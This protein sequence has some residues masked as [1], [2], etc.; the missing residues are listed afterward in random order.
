MKPRL[1]FTIFGVFIQSWLAQ[2]LARR[3]N[4]RHGASEAPPEPDSDAATVGP[5][6]SGARF[7]QPRLDL[8][9]R[10]AARSA[11][12]A[13]NKRF[14]SSTQAIWSPGEPWW[15]SG[16]A[17]A[18][19]T[20]YM[21]K[22]GTG[23]YLS[24]VEDMIRVQRAQH[25]QNGGEFRADSTDDTGWWAL[26]MIRMYDLT[27]NG[28]YLDISIEDETFMYKYWTSSP[29]GGG[30]YVDTKAKTYKNAIA[31]ELYIKLA[32]SLHNRIANDTKY[33]SRAETA[34][35]WFQRS[36]MI[37]GD[38]LINDGLAVSGNGFCSNNRLPVWTYNQGVILGALAELYR[39]TSSETYL[40]WAGRIADAV[41][42]NN[43]STSPQ[44]TS[45]QDGDGD[46]NAG[47]ILTEASCR[48]DEADGCDHDQQ[49]FKGVL[50]HNLAELDA[51]VPGRSGGGGGP[52][53]AYL[54]C[55]AQ[56]AYVRAREQATDLYDVA[57]AGPPFRNSTIGKQAS[58]V[59]LLVAVL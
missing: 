5:S 2:G 7:L 33:L 29:C 40:T 15:L 48:P 3:A 49:V 35:S 24:Q 58:A 13:M 54:E 4:P 17:L 47:G 25:P 55:N 6:L 20:D 41:L 43:G 36:G 26:A 27:G 42:S 31:N 59:S 28:T 56:S 45:P 16:V 37:K 19:V 34:W 52:Y 23:D 8:D 18:A 46:G 39:A 10:A 12:E 1:F 11:I 21:R 51:A 14:Y 44:L 30:I 32:A 38:N 57:W 9:V 50:A 53:R 22:T